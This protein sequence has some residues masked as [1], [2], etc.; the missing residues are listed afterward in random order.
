MTNQ[1]ESELE[2]QIAEEKTL[3][4]RGSI[5]VA[6]GL[7]DPGQGSPGKGAVLRHLRVSLP[8]GYGQAV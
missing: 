5:S 2:K 3:V 8:V 6:P 1:I 7:S 4:S